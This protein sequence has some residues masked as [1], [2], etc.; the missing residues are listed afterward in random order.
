MVPTWCFTFHS[1]EI[2]QRFYN[3]TINSF[4]IKKRRGNTHGSL[5]LTRCPHQISL[6][7]HSA[8]C[9]LL[10]RA[11]PSPYLSLPWQSVSWRII[12]LLAEELSNSELAFP[13]RLLFIKIVYDRSHCGTIIKRSRL[14]TPCFPWPQR[15]SSIFYTRLA[16]QSKWIFLLLMPQNMYILARKTPK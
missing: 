4:T 1:V 3:Q 16:I 9:T 13:Q 15:S 2:L 7:C 11:P 6:H 5:Q 10:S 12:N 14:H 8:H